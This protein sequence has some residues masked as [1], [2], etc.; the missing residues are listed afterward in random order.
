MGPFMLPLLVAATLSTT[1]IVQSVPGDAIVSAGKATV[2]WHTD[3]GTGQVPA[4]HYSCATGFTSVKQE[5]GSWLYFCDPVNV[6]DRIGK[7]TTILLYS[8]GGL[9]MAD[10]VTTI[11]ALQAGAKEQNIVLRNFA[12]HPIRVG[13]FKGALHTASIISID[14][15]RDNGK[16][17]LALAMAAGHVALYTYV[18][19]RNMK[20]LRDN[21]A[22][23]SVNVS[24]PVK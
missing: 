13:L 9:G 17:K 12:A 10:T 18:V 11:L 22:G 14:R 1:P 15:L 20:W 6:R 8:I 21:G 3:E 7:T 16:K 5:D 19:A 23:W 2:I 4:I 24:I